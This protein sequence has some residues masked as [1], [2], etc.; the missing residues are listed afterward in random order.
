MSLRIKTEAHDPNNLIPQ[1]DLAHL[2]SI[3]KINDYAIRRS[4]VANLDDTYCMKKSNRDKLLAE[5]R[6]EEKLDVAATEPATIQI[7][8]PSFKPRSDQE[9]RAP[10]SVN[11]SDD[12]DLEFSSPPTGKIGYL[13]ILK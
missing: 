3:V 9:N 8:S 5:A 13:I 6:K 11:V 2:E 10:F 7:K 4:A 12:E 1:H